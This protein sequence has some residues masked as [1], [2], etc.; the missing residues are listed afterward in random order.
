[1][2]PLDFIG[3]EAYFTRKDPDK[4]QTPDMK[5]HSL[6]R[7]KESGAQKGHQRRPLNGFEE[8]VPHPAPASESREG[9]PGFRK[10]HGIKGTLSWLPPG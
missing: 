7:K 8:I 2:V 3:A 4:L 1:V 9:N 6:Q 10:T 5:V